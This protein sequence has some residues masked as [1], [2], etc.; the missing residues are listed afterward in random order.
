[1]NRKFTNRVFAKVATFSR[2][3]SILLKNSKAE[4]SDQLSRFE[5]L[6]LDRD[7][8]IDK[9]NNLF[10]RLFN[11]KYSENNGMWSE[12]LVVMAAISESEFKVDNIL[13]IGTF[14]GQTAHILSNL[15]PESK[16][17]TIDLS[18]TT[19]NQKQIYN[20]AYKENNLEL[21]RSLLL[22]KCAN[23][24]FKALNSLSLVYENS[25]FDLIW[26]DGAHGY[27]T[28]AIDL[29]N[30]LRLISPR[31]IV[32]CDDVY[33]FTKSNDSEYNSVGA[34]ETLEELRKAG[35]IDFKLFLK[36]INKAYNYPKSRKKYVGVFQ[37]I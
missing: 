2:I 33:K 18:S 32:M 15:F 21:A 12:H 17:T 10:L 5:H 25:K 35:L 28:V 19:I 4:L 6:N 22:E 27:P 30:A 7:K 20:Y 13:E 31:G 9:L 8:A 1:M 24:E 14:D 37:K 36:R 29:I 3:N 11:C 16:I 23:V 26:V 34:F